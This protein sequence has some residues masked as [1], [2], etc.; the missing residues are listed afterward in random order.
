MELSEALER[1]R[2][3]FDQRARA[4]RDDQ[5]E[6]STPCDQ[7]TARDLVNHLVSEHLWAPSLLSGAA[8]DEV[9]D[10][11]DGDVVG[12][13][14]TGAWERA[15]G[16]SRVAFQRPEALEGEVHTS[17]GLAPATAYAWQMTQDLTVHAW[18]L[19]R[20][21]GADE[22]LDAG[23]ATAVLD[24]ARARVDH[25]Q[26]AGVFGPPVSVPAHAVA[27]DQLVALLGRHP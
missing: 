2:A 9:G 3:E 10:R 1:A 8:L 22:T 27:Q 19:A 20:S 18:D 6:N 13:D 7:W 21:I 5:W 17:T 14:P 23:L 26:G 25:W 4:V 15:S 24:Y 12:D 16:A 11:F